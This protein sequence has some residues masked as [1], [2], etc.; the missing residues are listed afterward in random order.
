MTNEQGMFVDTAAEANEL[1]ALAVKELEGKPLDEQEPFASVL[2]M[3][4]SCFRDLKKHPE[5]PTAK[6]IWL[7]LQGVA[8]DATAEYRVR[9]AEAFEQRGIEIGYLSAVAD[10]VVEET[11]DSVQATSLEEPAGSAEAASLPISAEVQEQEVLVKSTE[12]EMP[13]A[14][15]KE[16]EEAKG[17]LAGATSAWLKRGSK[18]NINIFKQRIEYLASLLGKDW[19]V[20]EI[21]PILLNAIDL[22]PRQDQDTRKG[23]VEVLE[24]TRLFTDDQLLLFE[25]ELK[26]KEVVVES[27]LTGT[28]EATTEAPE[29]EETLVY[30]SDSRADSSE[31]IVL[32]LAQDLGIDPQWLI[33]ELERLYDL[34]RKA[35]RSRQRGKTYKIRDE[36]TDLLTKIGKLEGGNSLL[37]KWFCAKARAHA[38]SSHYIH[39]HMSWLVGGVRYFVCEGDTCLLELEAELTEKGCMKDGQLVKPPVKAVQLDMSTDVPAAKNTVS[40]GTVSGD[41]LGTRE[42]ELKMSTSTPATPAD[43]G[44]ATTPPVA[45]PKVLVADLVTAFLS[46][47]GSDKEGAKEALVERAKACTPVELNEGFN[48][49]CEAAFRKLPRAKTESEIDSVEQEGFLVQ[50]ALVAVGL[51]ERAAKFALEIQGAA[52]KQRTRLKTEAGP[53]KGPEAKA[54]VSAEGDPNEVRRAVFTFVISKE[55]SQDRV[56]Q[57]TRIAELAKTR[58]TDI[59]KDV[60]DRATVAFDRI[61]ALDLLAIE[62]FEPRTIALVQCLETAN[63]LVDAAELS[64]RFKACIEARRKALTPP[65]IPKKST[66]PFTG[67]KSP[68][69]E[70]PKEAKKEATQTKL[71]L[72]DVFPWFDL[73]FWPTVL[74]GG[75]I[76]AIYFLLV[77]YGWWLS[78][79]VAILTVTVVGWF[80]WAYKKSLTHVLN[81]ACVVSAGAMVC[82]IAALFNGIGDS[83]EQ[84]VAKPEQAATAPAVAEPVVAEPVVSVQSETER[85]IQKVLDTAEKVQLE[86]NKLK[87]DLEALKAQQQ[88]PSP[89][90]ELQIPLPVEPAQTE[91]VVG[92][93]TNFLTKEISLIDL[94]VIGRNNDAGRAAFAGFFRPEKDMPFTEMVAVIL[95]HRDKIVQLYSMEDKKSFDELINNELSK[96]MLVERQKALFKN[97]GIDGFNPD[98]S[99]KAMEGQ[100]RNVDLLLKALK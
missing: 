96:K 14:A 47:T 66:R 44:K 18:N 31:A 12:I 79:T 98:G 7:F 29:V 60:Q 52:T 91:W 83:T 70:E 22:S 17:F 78:V 94:L 5:A 81:S 56:E 9:I 55:G 51:Q 21:A 10:E 32:T 38:Q 43:S 1:L 64:N 15:E 49:H 26:I 53:T 63:C 97:V 71:G 34:E 19:W 89:Q 82:V 86:N 50:E 75:A 13:T 59:V 67:L 69:A 92:G 72:G 27:V 25:R 6:E 46:A 73:E 84:V 74:C 45:P 88:D 77:Y 3:A 40:L 4:E 37:A 99:L 80:A 62:Q 30:E 23:V 20:D 85:R 57:S 33:P 68:V 90:P 28:S 16:L 61:E 24:A 39:G 35:F 93:K 76:V 42:G 100:Q 2:V 8:C 48:P 36:I 41:G 58:A 65:P 11:T 87:S 95:A 54:T